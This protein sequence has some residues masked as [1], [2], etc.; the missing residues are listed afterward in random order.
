MGTWTL[1]DAIGD[2]AASVR[3]GP[4]SLPGD[5]CGFEWRALRELAQQRGRLAPYCSATWDTEVGGTEHQ[6]VFDGCCSAWQKVT[7]RNSA[8]WFYD[9]EDQRLYPATPLQYLRRLQLSNQ[10]LRP[11]VELIGL[12]VGPGSNDLRIQT[13]QQ[14]VVGQSPRLEQIV[15]AF[16]QARVHDIEAGAY[17][18][19]ALQLGDYWIFDVCPKNF[20]L[21]DCGDVYA[22]DVL[23][24]KLGDE[25]LN[26]DEH[27]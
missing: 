23:V 25:L 14:H 16:P 6:C 9:F 24:Q 17:G 2:L 10:L 1:E 4:P 13:Q 20:V 3:A 21:S 7:H 18:S 5:R 19:I 8:G 27:A 22:I 15:Q 11:S 12:L 26:Y